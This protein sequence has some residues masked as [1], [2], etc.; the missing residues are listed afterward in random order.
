MGMINHI[1]FILFLCFSFS[2][3]CDPGYID[4]NGL[5]FYEN[6]INVLQKF[7][8]NSYATGFTEENCN[9]GDSYCGSPNPYMDQLDAW[10]WVVVDSVYYQ[11]GTYNGFQNENGQ[12]DPLELGLQE[13][14]N[15]RLTSIMCGAYIYCQLSGPIP[16]EINTLAETSVLRFEYNYLSGFAPESICDLD[17]DN[18]DYLDFDLTGNRICP[19]Y[20]EC[21]AQ[22]DFWYQ[23][24]SECTEIGDLNFDSTINIQD[25][26]LLVSFILNENDWDYQEFIAADYNQD[27]ELNVIDIV[28]IVDAILQID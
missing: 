26:I 2:Q 27:G 9:E 6:D 15:G 24:T 5:C 12:V 17:I 1:L 25:V 16:E 3:D 7:I 11:S 23:E 21:I 22:G 28:G 19:P 8:D 18:A 20:P 13:W 10:F 14:N 4:I